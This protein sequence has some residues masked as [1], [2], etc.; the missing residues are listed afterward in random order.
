MT[1]PIFQAMVEVITALTDS[2]YSFGDAATGIFT[3][4]V[5]SVKATITS[6]LDLGKEILNLI[7]GMKKVEKESH[8]A[9]LWPEMTDWIY[10][11][12]A[13]V[14]A[15]DANLA[16]VAHTMEATGASLQ[17]LGGFDNL[18]AQSLHGM[19]TTPG[20]L[21]PSGIQGVNRALREQLRVDSGL[22]TAPQRL[23]IAPTQ[24]LPSA[25]PVTIIFEGNNIVDDRSVEE[26][27]RLITKAQ[28]TQ[29]GRLQNAGTIR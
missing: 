11:A 5:D 8:G 25:P 9:S 23:P 21:T 26:L 19:L 15:L 27:A 22:P 6:V 2:T 13:A 10:T 14:G 4:V 1:L 29:G 3:G 7:P 24:G 12:D 28:T 18:S 16:H 17:A 20:L